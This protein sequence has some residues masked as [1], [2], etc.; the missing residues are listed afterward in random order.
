[1][2]SP[3][4]GPCGPDADRAGPAHDSTTAHDTAALADDS[5]TDNST[6]DNSTPDNSATPLADDST[7]DNSTPDDSTPDD[8][9]PDDSAAALADDSTTD[10]WDYGTVTS[11]ALPPSMRTPGGEVIRGRLGRSPVWRRLR[12]VWDWWRA[13]GSNPEPTD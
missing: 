11:A 4:P 10:D 9:T 6:P 13:W 1:M 5:A 7:T 2:A 3:G 12:G 8:S